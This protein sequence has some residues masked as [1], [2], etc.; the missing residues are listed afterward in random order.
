MSRKTRVVELIPDTGS[1][2]ARRFAK[3]VLKMARMKNWGK[4]NIGA[5]PVATVS[6]LDIFH[7]FQVFPSIYFAAPHRNHTAKIRANLKP[8]L[9]GNRFQVAGKKAMVESLI[10]EFAEVY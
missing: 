4:V 3:V 2:I 8:V 7:L 5:R 1:A 6:A 10:K 9:K